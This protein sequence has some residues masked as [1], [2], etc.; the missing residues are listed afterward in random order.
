[1]SYF[2]VREFQL[3]KSLQHR[4]ASLSPR[5]CWHGGVGPPAASPLSGQR[6][7]LQSE[8]AGLPVEGGVSAREAAALHLYLL[9]QHFPLN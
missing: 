5:R 3:T 9:S 7:Y 1:M 8:N 4:G 6:G 2:V